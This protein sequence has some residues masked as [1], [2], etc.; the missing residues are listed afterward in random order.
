MLSN[1]SANNLLYDNFF[2]DQT[3]NS[4]AMLAYSKKEIDWLTSYFNLAKQVE[5]IDVA[6]GPG[7][8]LKAFVELGFNP[9]GIDASPEC[10]RLAHENCPSIKDKI[11]EADFLSKDF[12]P[13]EFDLVLIAGISF[14]YDKSDDINQTL[15]EK[16]LLTT[17]KSGYLVIQYLNK[18][19]AYSDIK[20]QKTFWN[21]SK[22]MYVLDAR[23]LEND[24]LLSEKIFIFKNSAIQK[25]YSD[26]AYLYTD[27]SLLEK[28]SILEKKHDI[29]F[30]LVSVYDSLIGNKY[31]ETSSASPVM[32]LKR[33]N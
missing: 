3:F 26:V 7:R 5:I 4:P 1:K 33:T 2:L 15:L 27:K 19:W 23:I 12:V 9:T 28:V 31:S 13:N 22:D 20:N 14:G 8:H 29:K 11:F 32:I 6:C 16:L 25:K 24:L 21:E 30:E 18:L 17:R 10:I